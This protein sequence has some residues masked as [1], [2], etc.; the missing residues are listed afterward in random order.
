MKLLEQVK[1]K[2]RG[3]GVRRSTCLLVQIKV[4]TGSDEMSRSLD[5]ASVVKFVLV[6]A[7]DSVSYDAAKV[8]DVS[9]RW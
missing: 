7:I 4:F 2:Q 1:L 3:S 6:S 8:L 5:V 9:S